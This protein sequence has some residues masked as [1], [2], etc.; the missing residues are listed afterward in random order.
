M[1]LFF[2]RKVIIF[3]ELSQE[4]MSFLILSR[5]VVTSKSLKTLHF[6]ELK[7]VGKPLIGMAYMEGKF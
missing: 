7:M 6:E 4:A 5:N 3:R 2:P 1:W